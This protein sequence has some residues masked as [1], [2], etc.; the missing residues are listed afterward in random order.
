VT[1]AEHLDSPAIATLRASLASAE[2]LAAL[3]ALPGYQPLRSG[4]VLS[5]T[6]VL[7]WWR[8]RNGKARP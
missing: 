8:Y 7:P 5:L 4:E 6:E 1:L 2:W 3:A